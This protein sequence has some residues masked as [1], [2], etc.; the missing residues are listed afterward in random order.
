MLSQEALTIFM[1]YPQTSFL[2]QGPVG[3]DRKDRLRFY[4]VRYS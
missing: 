4:G 2:E 3:V 1:S